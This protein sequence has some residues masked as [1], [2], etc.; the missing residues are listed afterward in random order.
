MV[1]EHWSAATVASYF[2]YCAAAGGR[3]TTEAADIPETCVYWQRARAERAEKTLESAKAEG[4]EAVL[5]ELLGNLEQLQPYE[6][7][8]RA[9][10]AAMIVDIRAYLRKSALAGEEGKDG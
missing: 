3:C 9:G 1:C 8:L 5:N 4:A 7:Y 2:D 6:I 10:I